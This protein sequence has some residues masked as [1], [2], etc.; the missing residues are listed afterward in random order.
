MISRV[1]IQAGMRGGITY[2]ESSFCDQPFKIVDITENKKEG[3]M[4]LIMMN[5]SPGILDGDEYD[6]KINLADDCDVSL[7]TQSYQ[8]LFA[9][10]K[11]A[12]QRLE[13]RMGSGS[14]LSYIPH[15]VVPHSTSSFFSENRIY[16]SGE[17][18]LIWG[19]VLTCGR[20]LNGEVFLFSKY[21]SI[22]S[23]YIN[24]KLVIKENL[25]IDPAAIDMKTIGQLE[26]FTHQATLTCIQA[27]ETSA[28][29]KEVHGLLLGTEGISFGITA[30]PVQGF[31]VRILGFKAEQLFNCLKKIAGLI[32]TKKNQYAG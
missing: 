29:Q 15:P 9:M 21:H 2:L 30:A 20:N 4:H 12:R 13:I 25:L 17:C 18:S 31:V 6:I 14:S 24:D 22:T 19:E 16:V 11:S 1:N 32:S 23:F 8:R 10:K 27:E 28:I 3:R 5:C 7:G 26:G